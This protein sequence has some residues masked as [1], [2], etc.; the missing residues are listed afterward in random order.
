MRKR[1]TQRRQRRRENQR[2]QRGEEK[3]GGKRRK[4]NVF[5]KE[6]AT[7]KIRSICNVIP[8]AKK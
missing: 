3:E 8:D 7:Y 6:R 5:N 1:R 2:R 4:L